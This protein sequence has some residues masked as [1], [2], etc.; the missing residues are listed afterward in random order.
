MVVVAKKNTS[1]LVKGARYEVYSLYNSPSITRKVVYI[2]GLGGYDVKGFTDTNGNPLPLITIQPKVIDIPKLDFSSLKK[3]DLIVCN[4]DNYKT[5]VK[6]AKYKITDLKEK[7]VEYTTWNGAKA[8][9][10]YPKIKFEGVNRWFDFNSWRFR[11]LST[12]EIR[13]ISLSQVLEGKEPEVIK[14]DK[15]RKIDHVK[16]KEKE[17]ILYLSKAI[18]DHSRNNLDIIGWAT[19]IGSK[20]SIERSDYDSILDMTLKDIIAKLEN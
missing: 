16:N 6:D 20:M 12:E 4:S 7:V 10:T 14:T 13:E 2:K 11:G 3:G 19:K 15:L 9:R 18:F 17:L 1:K 8:T 5:I